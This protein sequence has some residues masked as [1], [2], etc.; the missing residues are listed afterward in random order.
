M[1]KNA[2]K[3]LFGK[4]GMY[5]PQ[6]T[7]GTWGIGGAGWD[8]YSDEDRLDAIRSAVECGITLIDTA[9]A[10]NA[11]EAE[12]YIG[13][14]L[15]TIGGRKEVM[16]VTKCGNRFIDGK[17]VRSGKAENIF[18]ECD[19]SLRNLRTDYIDVML[20]HWPDPT[21]PFSETFGALEELKKEGKV[22]HIGV[23]NFTREQIEEVQKTTELEVLQVQYSMLH[24]DNMELLKWAHAQGMGTMAYGALTGGLLTG[25]YRTVETYEASDS[26]NRFYGKYFQEPYFSRVM[27]LLDLM[28]PVADGH[29]ASLSEVAINWARQKDH[30]NTCIV[31]AQKRSRVEAN[32]RCLEW[33][34]SDAELSELDSA[35]CTIFG[36]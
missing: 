8:T 17:Y 27:K 18:A 13:K 22:L 11:G 4:T 29:G 5:I 9:P 14:A 35:L 32:A 28:Q 26:R 1:R 36:S 10:Y 3:T 16:L 21:V 15:E 34:L 25:R 20:V 7:L 19:D 24:R 30:V 12:R 23:S 31:G 6:M 33:E 2:G